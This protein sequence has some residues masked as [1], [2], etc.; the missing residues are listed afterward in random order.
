MGGSDRLIHG[1]IPKQLIQNVK[2]DKTFFSIKKNP[3]TAYIESASKI[4][5]SFVFNKLLCQS[6][7][8]Y[9]K[10]ENVKE[11]S[12]ENVLILSRYKHTD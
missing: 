2:C 3:L 4:R 1:S 10:S 7:F 11:H 12:H 5:Y 6:Q 8:L 9:R